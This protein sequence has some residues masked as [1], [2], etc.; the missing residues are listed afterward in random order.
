MKATLHC[1]FLKEEK[2]Y[3]TKDGK[4]VPAILVYDGERENL[5]VTGIS[6]ENFEVMQELALP[7]NIRSSDYGLM[8]NYHE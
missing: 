7:V 1:Y 3:T 5:R 8:I 4:Y 2:G 6:G